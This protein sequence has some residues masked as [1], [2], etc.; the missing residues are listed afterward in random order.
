M[1]RSSDRTLLVFPCHAPWVYQLGRLDFQLDIP[2]GLRGKYNAGWDERMRPV[3]PN[4]RLIS[5]DEALRSSTAY[6]CIIAHGIADLLDVRSRPEP[7]LLVLHNALEA[8]RRQEGGGPDRQEAQA[9]LQRYLSL[10]GGHVVATSMFKGESWGF[11]EDIVHASV[12]V[13]EYPPHRGDQPRGMRI[14]NYIHSRRHILL[15]EFHR[16]AFADIPLTLVGHNPDMPGVEAA[17]DWSHLKAMLQSH[18]F[19]VH[20]ADPRYE[21]G[22]NMATLEAMA[23]GLPVLGNAHPASPI[24]HGVTGFL[25]DDPAELRHWAKVLL[26]DEEL[27][28]RMGQQARRSVARQFSLER[29]QSA[30]ERSIE[31]ARH[32]HERS[33]NGKP[34]HA[35]DRASTPWAAVSALQQHIDPPL[36]DRRRRLTAGACF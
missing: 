32:K 19:Y 29:F 25:S 23:A 21:A 26:E 2:V 17:R 35:D 31:T 28:Y 9:M 11:T 16:E 3:P 12:D 22:Y 18:R 27:A 14:C 15:W 30:L 33:A 6:Y 13:G 34:R 7:R 4:A 20:T 36:W 24:E 5:L 1:K 8:R 10:I